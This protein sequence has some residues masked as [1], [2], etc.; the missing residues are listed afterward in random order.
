MSEKKVVLITGIAGY[1][2]GRVARRLLDEPGLKIIGLDNSPPEDEIVGLDF[3]Q[4]DVRNPLL[5]EFLE[6]EEGE[7]TSMAIDGYDFSFIA[8][9]TG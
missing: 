2:G 5:V 9:K 7:V 4:A 8:I 1:W 3:I 6:S